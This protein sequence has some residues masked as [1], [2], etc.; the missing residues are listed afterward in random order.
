MPQSTV[1]PIRPDE[2]HRV[3]ALRL[4]AVHDP[5]AALAF[6]DSVEHT[7][8]LPDA[9]WQERAAGA[10]G[11]RA[12]ARQVV[13]EDEQGQWVGTA[14]GLLGRAGSEDYEG[15]PVDVDGCAVVGVWIDPAHRGGTVLAELVQSL[16]EWSTTHDAGR[17]RLYVHSGNE[18]AR[19]AYEK[20]GFAVV[21]D[22]F[23][24]ALGPTLEMRRY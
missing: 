4:D 7:T 13:A 3:R 6:A 21:G 1:R 11:D 24:G 17:L 18:R 2:W 19:R 9:F 20:I 12:T 8:A 10:S 15:R 22:E 14:T 5:V 23:R 16:Q